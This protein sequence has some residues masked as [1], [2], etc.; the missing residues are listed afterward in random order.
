M[1]L[2]EEDGIGCIILD[3]KGVEGY[4]GGV[5]AGVLKSG[6]TVIWSRKLSNCRN[7]KALCKVS[8]GRI[9]GTPP[10]PSIAKN[11]ETFYCILPKKNYIVFLEMYVVQIYMTRTSLRDQKYCTFSFKSN[12]IPSIF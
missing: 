1:E 4:L 11:N 2:N 8:K 10:I 7:D 6:V 9:G 5:E 3:G 12:S